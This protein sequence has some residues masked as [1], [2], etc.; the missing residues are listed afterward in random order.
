LAVQCIQDLAAASIDWLALGTA[1]ATTR[2]S[3][4]S[5]QDPPLDAM[6]RKACGRRAT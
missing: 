1:A 3:R 4:R 2:L 6:R 5:S